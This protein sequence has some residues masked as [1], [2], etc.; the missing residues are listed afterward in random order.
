MSK[1]EIKTNVKTE[2]T[3]TKKEVSEKELEKVVG[4]VKRPNIVGRR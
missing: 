1:E 4:G 2:E 3:A